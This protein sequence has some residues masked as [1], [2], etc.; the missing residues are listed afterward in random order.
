VNKNV[1]ENGTQKSTQ[2][3]LNYNLP[4]LD[5]NLIVSFSIS[6]LLGRAGMKASKLCATTTIGTQK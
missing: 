3:S 1:V 5:F 6:N 2:K 4:L